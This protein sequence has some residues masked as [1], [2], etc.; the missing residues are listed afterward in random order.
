MDVLGILKASDEPSIRYKCSLNLSPRKPARKTLTALQ[1]EIA[2]SERV[3]ALLS[4]RDPKG[5][6]P[7]HPYAKWRG[8]HWVLADLADL[9]YPSGD[10]NLI[11]LREQ[12]YEWL[13]SEEHIDSSVLIADKWRRHASQE[14]N[15]MYYLN[16]LGLAD[17]RT[18][19]LAR[20]LQEM[21]W[22]DGGWNCRK[23]MDAEHSSFMESITPLR[24]HI[25]HAK[26]NPKSSVHD[27]IEE[28]A[29]IFLKRQLFVRQSN[30]NVMNSS[31][32]KLHHPL[33]WHYDILFGLKVLN[34]GDMLPDDRCNK[35][36]DLLESKR[37]PDGGFAA[38]AQFYR[39]RPSNRSFNCNVRWG[40]TGKKSMNEFVTVEA[41]T[42]LKAAGRA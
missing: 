32:K 37:L 5:C 12:V 39:P 35:A 33:Y 40:K 8:A 38:E 23:D 21:Q 11:P 6:I 9:G 10:E 2:S 7:L 22:P 42:V 20:R 13:F 41:L 34:E 1:H 25:A 18:E 36:L 4:E 3:K 30:G 31:F 19:L 17:E 24:G 14:G 29:D 28:T 27:R 26:A 16:T 15:A